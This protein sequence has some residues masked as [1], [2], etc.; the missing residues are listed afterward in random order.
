MDIGG[1]GEAMVDLLVDQNILTSVADLYRLTTLQNQMLLRRFP[2]IGEK[3]VAEIVE[4]L[5]LSKQQPLWRVLNA[6]GIPNVG[7]KIAQDL[8]EHLA[9]QQ[10]GNLEELIQAFSREE[11]QDL[12]GIGEKIW[13]GIQVFITTAETIHLLKDLEESGVSFAS[14]AQNDGVLEEK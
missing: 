5:E 12:Y 4:Q 6:L 14:S 9:E 7:K 8:A 13:Q 10:V 2:S 3:K 1:I 11:I